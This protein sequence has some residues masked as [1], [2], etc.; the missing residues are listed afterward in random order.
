MSESHENLER[1]YEL[2]IWPQ[3]PESPIVKKRYSKAISDFK[4]LINHEWFQEILRRKNSIRILEI[5]SGTGLGGIA[6]AKV[7]K[8]SGKK[9]E[10]ILSDVREKALSIGEKWGSDELGEKIR[11]VNINALLIHKLRIK[12]DIV[13]MYGF[14]SPHFNPWEFTKLLASISETLEDDG[15][16]ILEETDRVYSILFKVGY[17]DV[18]IERLDDKAIISLHSSYDPIKGT[19]ERA[20]IN[21]INPSTPVKIS[22]Y[23]WNIAELM[24]LIWLFFQDIDYI[25]YDKNKSSGIIIAYNPRRKIKPIDLEYEPKVL[26]EIKE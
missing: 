2:D 19:F 16:L 3:N 22:T 5:C 21:L 18:V 26:K 12:S 8:E 1:L 14:S 11:V 15:I 13:L 17:K 7:L 10:L 6:L 20:Y 23:F 9:V 24:T 4:N 25:P